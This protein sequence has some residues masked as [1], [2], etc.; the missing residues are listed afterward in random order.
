M[1][2]TKHMIITKC[3]RPRPHDPA[4]PPDPRIPPPIPPIPPPTLYSVKLPSM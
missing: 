1:I 3:Y 2:T 4:I